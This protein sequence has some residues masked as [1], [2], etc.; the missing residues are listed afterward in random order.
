MSRRSWIVATAGALAFGLAAAAALS[1]AP[2]AA[3]AGGVPK[4]ELRTEQQKAG[5][6]IGL[7]VGQNFSR[8]QCDFDLD[9]FR[10]GFEDAMK[11]R[12][13]LMTA[14]QCRKTRDTYF[15]RVQRELPV[16]NAKAGKDF[17]AANKKK[18]GVVE[19]RSGLQYIVIKEGSGARP[20]ATDSVRV[21]Y[22]GRF[23]DGTEFDSSHWHKR[24][25]E[26]RVT[27]GV[28][29]GW[30]EAL[31]LM[32]VGSKYKLFVPGDLAYGERPPRGSPITP[33]ALLIFEVEL[34][35]IIK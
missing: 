12:A 26:F 18:P 32:K 10:R 20:K 34:L 33:N 28:I 23:T 22:T 19:T 17:L 11:R 14:E 25:G 16:K 24:P 9:A 27:G 31:Q 35:S 2:L 4:L 30:T 6:A 3:D 15:K 13:K 29:K 21:H 5:Y 7:Q 1:S 8:L